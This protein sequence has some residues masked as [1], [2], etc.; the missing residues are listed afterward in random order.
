MVGAIHELPLPVGENRGFAT[1]GLGQDRATY[2]GWGTSAMI[3]PIKTQ[4]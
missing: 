1:P 3:I 2:V 4:G